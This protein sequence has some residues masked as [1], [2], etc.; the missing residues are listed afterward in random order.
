MYINVHVRVHV[1]AH[2]C[3]CDYTYMYTVLV[4]YFYRYIR[5]VAHKL[6]ERKHFSVNVH[7]AFAS[8]PGG[9]LQVRINQQWVQ[10]ETQ[11]WKYVYLTNTSVFA[12]QPITWDNPQPIHVHAHTH[13][14]CAQIHV[15]VCTVSTFSLENT[16]GNYH[17]ECNTRQQLLC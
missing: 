6:S 2:T 5:G 1:H 4:L 16:M 10:Q 3:T 7:T 15:H 14:H 9:F 17:I 13:I 12:N 8:V 11:L